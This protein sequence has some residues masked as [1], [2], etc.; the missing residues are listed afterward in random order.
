[1]DSPDLD[2]DII[3]SAA[4]AALLP[5]IGTSLPQVQ[6]R[7]KQSVPEAVRGTRSGI[8]QASA[9]TGVTVAATETQLQAAP[10][11]RQMLAGEGTAKPSDARHLMICSTCGRQPPQHGRRSNAR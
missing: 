7:G 10:P 5:P 1:M 11:Q 9:W 3:T 6:G 2:G 8:A 4:N